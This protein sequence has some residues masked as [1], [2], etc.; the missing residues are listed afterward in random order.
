M[1]CPNRA[2]SPRQSPSHP[3]CSAPDVQHVERDVD[4]LCPPLPAG[5][6]T[7]I[8]QSTRIGG[9]AGRPTDAQLVF[10]VA[11]AESGGPALDPAMPSASLR[12]CQALRTSPN[13]VYRSRD[14]AVGDP[15]LLA[16]QRVGRPIGRKHSPGARVQRVGT[17][18]RFGQRIRP[19]PLARAF[20]QQ[21]PASCSGVRTKLDRQRTNPRMRREGQRRRE[22]CPASRSLRQRWRKSPCP[23]PSRRIPRAHPPTAAPVLRLLSS[24]AASRRSPLPQWP[25]SAAPPRSSQSRTWSAQSGDARR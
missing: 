23:S 3:A 11:R 8:L 19:H 24:A 4:A 2:P 17:R 15:H 22:L 25:R 20:A 12:R 13:T 6:A 1:L 21:V 14:A 9:V 10:L 7:G 5:F 18:R 16:I